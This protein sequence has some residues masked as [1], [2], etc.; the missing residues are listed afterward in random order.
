MIYLFIFLPVALALVLAFRFLVIP[1]RDRYASRLLE[2]E[3]DFDPNPIDQREFEYHLSKFE[4]SFKASDQAENEAR[5]MP[6]PNYR[7][8]GPTDDH[9]DIMQQ[10]VAVIDEEMLVQAGAKEGLGVDAGIYD[11]GL[12]QKEKSDLA[13]GLARFGIN[14]G[15]T[16]GGAFLGSKFGGIIGSFLFPGIGTLIGALL[17]SVLGGTAGRLTAEKVRR[18]ALMTAIEAY[19]AGY[20][21]A[22]KDLNNTARQS[23]RKM[24]QKVEST[25]R[26]YYMEF[27]STPRHRNDREELADLARGLADSMRSDIDKSIRDLR[28][29]GPFASIPRIRRIIAGI[30]STLIDHALQ[31]P[32]DRQIAMDPVGSFRQLTS[33][34]VLAQG[35]GAMVAQLISRALKEINA[36]HDDAL[37]A[38]SVTADAA[39]QKAMTAIVTE[40]KVHTQRYNEKCKTWKDYLHD[41]IDEIDREKGK[42]GLE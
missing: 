26:D 32:A 22:V 25:R 3:P 35:Q 9:A 16:G 21:T 28:V 2:L 34:P 23:A 27:G 8:P 19:N 31:I 29:H 38:W 20:D 7:E 33:L 12:V 14:L 30:R 36:E 42:L 37:F 41:K 39:Y 18:M 40:L 6:F 24:L 4:L 13:G 1:L 11:W 17:G 15:F 10:L 5:T